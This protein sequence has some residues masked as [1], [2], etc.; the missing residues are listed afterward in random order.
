MAVAFL[1][2]AM[3]VEFAETQVQFKPA[4]ADESASSMSFFGSFTFDGSGSAGLFGANELE[5]A[6]KTSTGSGFG[7][8]TAGV[9]FTHVDETVYFPNDFNN[10]LAKVDVPM[11]NDNIQEPDET[12]L[13]EYSVVSTLAGHSEILTGEPAKGTITDVEGLTI[14]VSDSTK[15]EGVDAAFSFDV[16]MSHEASFDF[17]MVYFIQDEYTDGR[18]LKNEDIKDPEFSQLVFAANSG[19]LSK[20]FDIEIIDDNVQEGVETFEVLVQYT[21]EGNFG[22]NL[23]ATGT[24]LEETEGVTVCI[25]AVTMAEGSDTEMVF[26]VKMSHSVSADVNVDITTVAG[27]NEGVEI[28]ASEKSD[29]GVAQYGFK[30]GSVTFS[31]LSTEDKTFAVEIPNDDIQSPY[32][33]ETSMADF[34]RVNFGVEYTLAPEAW[35]GSVGG[36]NNVLN[37]GVCGSESQAGVTR[38]YVYDQEDVTLSLTASSTEQTED[39][40]T[41]F[42][43]TVTLSHRVIGS[44]DGAA[45]GA[46]FLWKDDNAGSVGGKYGATLATAPTLGCDSLPGFGNP[47]TDVE[48]GPVDICWPSNVKAQSA[49]ESNP[50]IFTFDPVLPG[51]SADVLPPNPI[52]ITMAYGPSDNIVEGDETFTVAIALTEESAAGYHITLVESSANGTI[53]DDDFATFT[54]S[55]DAIIDEDA[56][57]IVEYIVTMSHSVSR[58][59]TYKWEVTDGTATVNTDYLVTE[60]VAD[61]ALS[62]APFSGANTYREVQFALIDDNV[63]ELSETFSVSFTEVLLNGLADAAFVTDPTT[64]TPTISDSEG[65]SISINNMKTGLDESITAWPFTVELSHEFSYD[66]ALN[67]TTK[68]HTTVTGS[69]IAVANHRYTAMTKGFSVPAFSTTKDIDISSAVINDNVQTLG[70]DVVQ[71]FMVELQVSEEF[72]TAVSNLEASALITDNED[73]TIS[74]ADTEMTEGSSSEMAFPITLSHAL[75]GA[76]VEITYSTTEGTASS[77]NDYQTQISQTTTVAAGL[78]AGSVSVPVTDDNIQEQSETFKITLNSVS[79]G[80]LPTDAGLLTVTGNIVDDESIKM[81][82]APVSCDEGANC[83]FTLT[84]TGTADVDV[85]VTYYLDSGGNLNA[86]FGED[87]SIPGTDNSYATV[88]IPAGDSSAEIIVATIDDEI[89][90]M[91][92]TFTLNL[93]RVAN[94]DFNYAFDSTNGVAIGTIGGSTYDEDVTV[95]VTTDAAAVAKGTDV[96]FKITLSHEVAD[97]ILINYQTNDGSAVS[98]ASGDYAQNIGYKSFDSFSP[99]GTEKTVTVTTSIGACQEVQTDEEF[100]VSIQKPTGFGD[101]NILSATATLEFY[102]HNPTLVI[103]DASANEDEVLMF[104]VTLSHCIATH[105]AFNYV[106]EGSDNFVSG[107]D[108]Q[109]PFT[110]KI[111]FAKSVDSEK[112]TTTLNVSLIN[113]NV[114]SKVD[115]TL[116]VSIASVSGYDLGVNFADASGTGTIV[117]DE[118]ATL[119]IT[120]CQQKTIDDTDQDFAF[121]VELSHALEEDAL[122][123]TY[124]TITDDVDFTAVEGTDFV[125]KSGEFTFVSTHHRLQTLMFQAISRPEVVRPGSS[126][127]A[128]PAPPLRFGVQ[129][130][131]DA[132]MLELYKVEWAEGDGVSPSNVG[133]AAIAGKGTT[134]V[135]M[136]RVTVTEGDDAV[137]TV[138]VTDP[139]AQD[140]VVSYKAVPHVT[141]GIILSD[142]GLSEGTFTIAKNAGANQ[143][144][145]FTIPTT[146]DNVM[147]LEEKFDVVLTILSPS[148]YDDTILNMDGVEQAHT[149]VDNDV[150]TLSILDAVANEAD[151]KIVFTASLSSHVYTDVSFSV[152]TTGSGNAVMSTNSILPSVGDVV[153]TSDVATDYWLPAGNPLHEFDITFP[154]TTESLTGAHEMTFEIY[155]INDD[156]QEL[157]ETFGVKVT[158][159]GVASVAPIS[160]EKPTA[161]ATINDNEGVLF[162]FT[163]PTHDE[164]TNFEFGVTLSHKLSTSTTVTYKTSNLHYVEGGVDS[165]PTAT[166]GTHYVAKEGQF[167]LDTAGTPASFFIEN[168]DNEILSK[169]VFF[170]VVMVAFENDMNLPQSHATGTVIDDDEDTTITVTSDPVSEE[171]ESPMTF[172]LTLSHTV[173]TMVT[174]SYTA[175][176]AGTGPMAA[177]ANDFT[178]V[179]DQTMTMDGTKETPAFITVAVSDD[180]LLEDTETVELKYSVAS[181][182]YPF[183]LGP[184]I[185]QILSHEDATLTIIDGLGQESTETISF[186]VFMSHKVDSALTIKYNTIHGVENRDAWVVEK[187]MGNSNEFGGKDMEMAFESET[188]L[189]ASDVYFA[190]VGF[191]AGDL[192][193][194]IIDDDIVELDET[195]AIEI[196]G[197]ADLLANHD[198]SIAQ[199]SAVGTIYDDEGA[200]I[201]ISSIES[202]EDVG[203]VLMT[204]EISHEVQSFVMVDWATRDGFATKSESSALSFMNADYVAKTGTVTFNG[205]FDDVALGTDYSSTTLSVEVVD[206]LLTEVT[207]ED[208]CVTLQRVKDEPYFYSSNAVKLSMIFADGFI[209]LVNDTEHATVY[210]A[211]TLAMEGDVLTFNVMMSH[212]AQIGN[213]EVEYEIEEGTATVADFEMPAESSVTIMKSIDQQVASAAVSIDIVEDNLVEA[214]EDFTITL[215]SVKPQQVQGSNLFTPFAGAVTLS[216]KITATGTIVQEAQ[217]IIVGDA[218]AVEGSDTQIIFPVTLSGIATQPVEVSYYTLDIASAQAY[219]DDLRQPG[220]VVAVPQTNNGGA[221]A[222]FVQTDTTVTIAQGKNST[223]IVIDLVDNNVVQNDRKMVVTIFIKDP[224][225]MTT[226]YVV[227]REH[228]SAVGVIADDDTVDITVGS[229]TCQ[230]EDGELVFPITLSNP[231]AFEIAFTFQLDQAT[232]ISGVR[233]AANDE[234]D[235]V[236]P[237]QDGSGTVTI[238]ALTTSYDGFVVEVNDDNVQEDAETFS[239]RASDILSYELDFDNSNLK[240]VGDARSTFAEG[241]ILD[242]EKVTVSVSNAEFEEGVTQRF[243]VELSH[244][245]RVDNEV[246][247]SFSYGTATKED[248]TISDCA[249]ESSCDVLTFSKTNQ[250][251]L[252]V[253]AILIQ[254]TDDQKTEIDE[255]FTVTLERATQVGAPIN[256]ADDGQTATMTI[257]D[258]DVCLVSLDQVSEGSETTG[259]ISFKVSFSHEVEDN[260]FYSV[261]YG[262]SDAATPEGASAGDVV[263]PNLANGGFHTS[264]LIALTDPIRLVQNDYVTIDGVL[265]DAQFTG[266]IPEASVSVVIINDDE[267][268]CDETFLFK[269]REL[270]V[271]AAFSDRIKLGNSEAV[272]T[273]NNDDEGLKVIITDVSGSEGDDKFFYSISLSHAV[274]RELELNLFSEVDSSSQSRVSDC[275]QLNDAAACVAAS[276]R[277]V[278]VMEHLTGVT[279]DSSVRI[280]DDEKAQPTGSFTINAAFS[281]STPQCPSSSTLPA[282][283]VD[284]GVM[285]IMDNE[286]ATVSI[287]DLSASEDIAGDFVVEFTL[288]APL[289]FPQTIAYEVLHKSTGPEDFVGALDGSLEFPKNTFM[290]TVSFSVNNDDTSEA[291]EQLNIQTKDNAVT[292]H[293]KTGVLTIKNDDYSGPLLTVEVEG[294]SSASYTVT[295][296][297]QSVSFEICRVENVNSHLHEP[298]S[299]FVQYETVGTS[300][301]LYITQTGTIS[302][303]DSA[304]NC[305]T[306]VVQLQ[307]DT[308]CGF[309]KDFVFKTTIVSGDIRVDAGDTVDFISKRITVVDDD[310]ATVSLSDGSTIPGQMIYFAAT[311]E[312]PN[313]GGCSYD[314]QVPIVIDSV[315]TTAVQ[316]EDYVE[317][318]MVCTIFANAV[319]RTCRVGIQTTDAADAKV[320]MAKIDFDSFEN[321]NAG[322]SGLS[323]DSMAAKGSIDN[324]AQMTFATSVASADEGTSIAVTVQLSRQALTDFEAV[325][326]VTSDHADM[327]G[328]PTSVTVPAGQTSA[329]FNVDMDLTNGYMLDATATIGFEFVSTED[330]ETSSSTTTLLRRDLTPQSL[331]LSGP[332]LVDEGSTATF[333]VQLQ[334]EVDAPF[335]LSYSISG[336]ATTMNEQTV[337]QGATSIDIDVTAGASMDLDDDD[338]TLTVVG[339]PFSASK[340]VIVTDIHTQQSPVP[341]AFSCNGNFENDDWE[342]DATQLTLYPDSNFVSYQSLAGCFYDQHDLKYTMSATDLAISIDEDELVLVATAAD[343]GKTETIT[344]TAHDIFGG[345]STIVINVVVA[346]SINEIKQSMTELSVSGCTLTPGASCFRQATSFSNEFTQACVGDTPC[347]FGRGDIHDDDLSCISE[348]GDSST[349]QAVAIDVVVHAHDLEVGTTQVCLGT[350]TSVFNGV[351][352][353]FDGSAEAQAARC[354]PVTVV[355]TVVLQAN[356]PIRADTKGEATIGFDSSFNADDREYMV[357]N[358]VTGEKYDVFFKDSNR[359]K[360]YPSSSGPYVLYA[361]DTYS[362]GSKWYSSA[363]V[364]ITL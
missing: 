321:L 98:G 121:T 253:E 151:G 331:T 337:E 74:V 148:G 25:D 70:T 168:V 217:S 126:D 143:L 259:S 298:T 32:S 192:Q 75:Y 179:V 283:I 291:D 111:E 14:T 325:L 81:S 355:N 229:G 364:Q 218:S 57:G 233:S 110:K 6:V 310:G 357:M 280:F 322:W 95:L 55:E 150:A 174:I 54:I 5:I 224:A 345:K 282:L 88:T 176:A 127:P 262:S 99:V 315:G 339:G 299:A 353:V 178:E 69:Q 117:D 196:V 358:G 330:Y 120:Q 93:I 23:L 347:C 130:D 19:E 250:N 363:A 235:F 67:W 279:F 211:D 296:G 335:T 191:L 203:S 237:N 134:T 260:A 97:D 49:T 133:K 77:V 275:Y 273:I 136:S 91:A 333:T 328:I 153:G 334:N 362:G 245:I 210:V 272:G 232:A 105:A 228:Q 246:A 114:Q 72:S 254:I 309:Q 167:T 10:A 80:S 146:D 249:S 287:S 247:W 13:L 324:K 186:S 161:T 28:A 268:E 207:N 79:Y 17:N 200:I 318:A 308:N 82:I 169:D 184:A 141:D 225:S 300:N 39:D 65:A 213:F 349:N 346:D 193:V 223:E 338:F 101:S 201:S 109:N 45:R 266:A 76:A 190:N 164:S 212:A 317:S 147:E 22:G 125:A 198:V 8:A 316:G 29:S 137:F 132:D 332:E 160:V 187:R 278:T 356:G 155:I 162:I 158:E 118:K 216:D 51:N 102:D 154:A 177:D 238:P 35:M 293:G 123:F 144:V 219:F 234:N 73:L 71:Q 108:F 107:K 172:A 104:D 84:A 199:G 312:S 292:T 221:F 340:T 64:R 311:V 264:S 113:N 115:K 285:T 251:D 352:T 277:S 33:H 16:T 257:K 11:L 244:I 116:S 185:G 182:A 189:F 58:E 188:V 301:G 86:L 44:Q 226:N 149:L 320:L 265:T 194:P 131:A 56:E 236:M 152:V 119:T 294:L 303:L 314:I 304:F 288:S 276:T 18:A 208:F 37:I 53:K 350:E 157:S 341:T 122:A 90:E 42:S 103:A 313:G 205:L 307:S 138:K 38:G 267:Q 354:F 263:F 242:D 258:D 24:F 256:I 289:E 361:K 106:I 62:W 215:T 241:T 15:T 302:F 7:A 46:Q 20:T 9:D 63:Q 343:A 4:F 252:P 181:P 50:S 40:T 59:V 348:G 240:F 85:E 163:E 140:V 305:E 145:N 209:S 239:V 202:T 124:K 295:E 342:R 135:F 306:V 351:T 222:D 68:A 360:F 326:T 78:I 52:S 173:D 142:L 100:T 21:T 274:D 180:F 269:I 248:I 170:E 290:Q 284:K 230:E 87:F 227:P 47:A 26:T 89:A 286:D 60:V 27:T 166:A 204:V 31:A 30:S 271:K 43:Y 66:L 281:P 41:D 1:A 61:R 92:E 319:D 323:I 156:V 129:V 128:L 165:A 175:T 159:T 327:F 83:T 96:E 195:F 359:A 243:N 48:Q 139:I 171:S 206:D 329:T 3:S 112:P 336:D 220:V 214:D 297:E 2:T 34:G 270:S 231:V 255:T 183:T 344:V 12:F 197:A 261:K 36:A 94:Q